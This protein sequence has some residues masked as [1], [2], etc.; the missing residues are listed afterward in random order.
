MVVEEAHGLQRRAEPGTPAAHAVELF[1]ALLA[2]I[3]AY[4]EGIHVAEQIPTKFS[5]SGATAG[6]N[7]S[8]S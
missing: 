7:S 8:R 1:T 4:G 6:S 2:D 5:R 3:R